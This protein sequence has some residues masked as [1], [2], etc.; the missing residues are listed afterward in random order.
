MCG[1]A[2]RKYRNLRGWSQKTLAAKC[3]IVGLDVTRDVIATIEGRTRWVG[4]FELVL[5]AQVLGIPVIDLLPDRIDIKD[6]PVS[7]LCE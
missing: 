1:P 6:L 5:L 3:Q 4:D 2:V 7:K